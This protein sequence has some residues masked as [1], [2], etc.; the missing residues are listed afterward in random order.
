MQFIVQVLVAL[1]SGAGAYAAIR[2]D[3]ARLHERANNAKESADSAHKRID[4]I[5]RHTCN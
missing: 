1:A 2:A 5:M 4:N 3:L